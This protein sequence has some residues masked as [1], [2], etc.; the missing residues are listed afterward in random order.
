MMSSDAT[1]VE[2]PLR[3]ELQINVAEQ[4]VG[5]PTPVRRYFHHVLGTAA[6]PISFVR[7]AQRGSLRTDAASTPWMPFSANH[8]PKPPQRKFCWDAKVQIAPFFHLR[9]LDGYAEGVGTGRIQLFSVFT[10]ASDQNSPELKSAALHRYLAESVW[11]PTALLPSAG[12][13]WSPV[14]NRR[15]LATL[16]NSGT[17]VSLEFRFNNACEVASVYTS[18]RYRRVRKGLV[19]SPW[20]G[21]FSH[22]CLRQGMRVPGRG[23]VGWYRDG[24]LEIVWRAEITDL[25]FDLGHGFQ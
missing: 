6:R 21:S 25:A 9:I 8:F 10:L 3:T 18:G 16:T 11:Y 2:R 5:L 13:R 23:E 19:L 22:Y 24:K 7:I 4:C 20:G 1:R 17:A 14:D 12:V 15:A